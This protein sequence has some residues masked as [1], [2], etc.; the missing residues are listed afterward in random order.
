AAPQAN[1]RVAGRDWRDPTTGRSFTER[2]R[3]SLP[4]DIAPRV[5]FDGPVEHAE[6]PSLL[7]KAQVCVYPSHMESQGIVVIEGMAMGKAVVA[8]RTGPGPELID[9]G[10]AGL[11]CDPYDPHSIATQV[12]RALNDADLRLRLGEQ[13]RRRAVE[14]F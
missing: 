13:G 12:I 9:D 6:L 7:A 8:S 11:L 5:V 4:P 10:I 14:Q 1:L 3:A 2:L